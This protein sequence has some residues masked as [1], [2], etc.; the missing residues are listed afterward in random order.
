MMMS[1][2]DKNPVCPACGADARLRFKQMEENRQLR[3]S[4][5]YWRVLAL[6]LGLL[7]LILITIGMALWLERGWRIDALEYRIEIQKQRIEAQEGHIEDQGGRIEIYQRH[8][9]EEQYDK[10]IQLADLCQKHGRLEDM[11][12]YVS[13][14]HKIDPERWEHRFIEAELAHRRLDFKRALEAWDFVL[15]KMPVRTDERRLI[16]EK[17]IERRDEALRRLADQ[18]K[19]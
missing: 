19:P 2:N 7:F 3:N 14:A 13:E 5:A 11:E 12:I 8:L 16:R 17:I 18:P 15:R 6:G 1:T 10:K 9:K 4:C